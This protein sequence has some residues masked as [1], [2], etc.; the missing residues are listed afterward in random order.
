M[1]KEDELGDADRAR[2]ALG[3]MWPDMAREKEAADKLLTELRA[4][5]KE[6][7]V[8]TTEPTAEGRRLLN[9]F[10]G[11]DKMT[12]GYAGARHKDEPI[13]WGHSERRM[14][15]QGFNSKEWFL[16]RLTFDYATGTW[17]HED[18][19]GGLEALCQAVAS[20][21]KEEAK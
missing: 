20:A 1:N 3:K 14:N 21:F 13:T 12:L 19:R 11:G 5:L 8:E 4:M 7:K 16:L 9:V 17:R 6:F 18:G 15:V 10:A 2:R